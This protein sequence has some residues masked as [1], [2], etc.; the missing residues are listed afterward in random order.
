MASYLHR[1]R[2]GNYYSRVPFPLEL[3]QLG[4]PHEVRISLLTKDRAIASFRN[5]I[6]RTRVCDLILLP[7]INTKINSSWCCVCSM[8]RNGDLFDYISWLA[9]I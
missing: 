5:L 4:F 9:T 6:G 3:K 7:F 1:N 8:V 2:N